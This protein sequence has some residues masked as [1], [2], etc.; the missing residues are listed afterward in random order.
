MKVVRKRIRM[1][2]NEAI[3]RCYTDIKNMHMETL[4]DLMVAS[5]N[6]S[7]IPFDLICNEIN[8]RNNQ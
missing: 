5:M 7:K 1:N 3:E 8:R 2:M 4:S 6:N